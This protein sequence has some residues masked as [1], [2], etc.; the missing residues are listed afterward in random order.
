[1]H[2]VWALDSSK[3]ADIVVDD[4]TLS[5]KGDWGWLDEISS[6]YRHPCSG[7]WAYIVSI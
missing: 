3:E 2:L 1:V 4:G 7:I 5:M 6:H